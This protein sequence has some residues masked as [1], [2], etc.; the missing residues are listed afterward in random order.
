MSPIARW[1]TRITSTKELKDPTAAR[2][3]LRG[4]DGI[5]PRT[6]IVPVSDLVSRLI[7][8]QEPLLD[9]APLR[10]KPNKAC[11]VNSSRPLNSTTKRSN[12]HAKCVSPSVGDAERLIRGRRP[13]P[14]SA[15]ST[16]AA[17]WSRWRMR[18]A[19]ALPLRGSIASLGRRAA[20]RSVAARSGWVTSAR[21]DSR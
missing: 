11:A 15:G 1:V 16:P 18:C 4:L 5:L 2:C 9:A 12:K 10:R 3:A 14:P 7:E 17:R 13:R 20:R 6:L 21:R 19:W 8:F